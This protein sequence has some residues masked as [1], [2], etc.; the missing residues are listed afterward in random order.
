M[1]SFNFH[2]NSIEYILVDMFDRGRNR[3]EGVR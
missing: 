1:V 2:K 3:P